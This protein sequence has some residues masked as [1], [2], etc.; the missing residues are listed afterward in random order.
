MIAQLLNRDYLLALADQTRAE[1]EG[2]VARREAGVYG[3]PTD[4]DQVDTAQLQDLIAALNEAALNEGRADAP[5]TPAQPSGTPPPPKDDYAFVPRSPLMSVLQTAFDEAASEAPDEVEEVQMLDDRRSGPMPIITDRRLKGES[6][7]ITPEGRRV[8]GRMEIARR[9]WLSDPRWLFSVV[10]MAH[11]AIH[12]RVDFNDKPA[13]PVPIADDARL[14]ILGDWGS[15]LP[16][17]GEVAKQI[18]RV[19]DDPAEARREKHVIHLG[20]VYYSGKANEYLERFLGPW[21]VD[22]GEKDA[23]GSYTLNGNHDMYIGGQDYFGTCLADQRFSRQEKSSWF[24]LSNDNWQFLALDTAYEDAGLHG[25][26]AKWVREQRAA[27][28]ARKTVLLSHH[29]L[30]S[31]YESGA[32][33]LRRKIGPVLEDHPIDASFWGR[34]APVSRVSGP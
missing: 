11:R 27:A 13:K 22:P 10:A 12:G 3:A 33:A 15:G 28:P 18:R 34:D 31:A 25:D 32:V 21:P 14:V 6:L 26:Q 4:L 24:S 5:P 17:A 30:F 8:W 2:T 9:K 20:D 16:R 29:Q 1:L 19:L 23:I 7:N